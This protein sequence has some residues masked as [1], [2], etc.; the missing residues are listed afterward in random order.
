MKPSSKL[1][2]LHPNFAAWALHPLPL[3]PVGG[4][5]QDKAEEE[6]RKLLVE[7]LETAANKY[8]HVWMPIGPSVDPY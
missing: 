4:H 1:Q 7:E 2:Y 5:V 3:Q 6:T 8:A